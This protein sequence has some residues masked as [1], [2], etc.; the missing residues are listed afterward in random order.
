M[1]KLK[2]K[3]RSSSWR[4]QAGQAMVEYALILVLLAIAAGLTL[5]TY[6]SGKLLPIFVA[7]AC[8]YLVVRWRLRGARR[9]VP[10]SLLLAIAAGLTF[11]PH[12]TFLV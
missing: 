2:I 12:A 1:V 11:L 8:A 10:L 6:G 9:F 4:A 7:L 3:R 5:Y